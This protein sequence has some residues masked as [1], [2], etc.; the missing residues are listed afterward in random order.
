VVIDVTLQI[1]SLG[2]TAGSSQ[3]VIVITEGGKEVHR[4]PL[5]KVRARDLTTMF[6]LDLAASSG[7]TKLAEARAASRVFLERLDP[8]IDSGLVV[9]DRRIQPPPNRYPAGDPQAIPG[10]R[11]ELIRLT[12][13]AQP[14]GS[15]GYL[16]AS[17]L[18]LDM[19]TKFKG[20]RVV[21]LLTDG[22]NKKSD[23]PAE[24]VIRFANQHRIPVY[25]LGV[26]DPNWSEQVST[27][28]VLD[29]SGSMKEK[30]D[31]ADT[32]SKMDALKD[33]ASRFVDLMK[34]GG[35]AALLP[36]SSRVDDLHDFTPDKGRLKSQIS[37]LREEGGTAFYDAVY[38]GVEAVVA[39]RPEG[40]RHVVALT[41][42]VDEDPGSR[43]SP[44]QV[45]QLAR[46]EGVQLFLLGLGRR[47]D[48]NEEVMSRMAR[49]TG[50]R[51][52]H[53]A[54]QA[55]LFRAFETLSRDIH[56]DGLDE[57]ALRQLAEKTGG[58]YYHVRDV[59]KLELMYNDLVTE[60]K[61]RY[62]VTFPSGN[63]VMDALPS[64][65]DVYVVDAEGKKVS[66]VARADSFRSGLVVAQTNYVVYLV[67]L[68]ILLVLLK[69]PSVLRRMAS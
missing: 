61:E 14:D 28:L 43:H 46:E 53:A 26:G 27:V 63:Q 67:L 39:A 30:A 69:V 57:E 44:D 34:P 55:E 8:K 9:F 37:G 12:E 5:D 54:N 59:R 4:I 3:D 17:H 66:D 29:H 35:K 50:G 52:E 6:A 51:Y 38:T 11:R 41:D 62:T 48:I 21:V 2:N 60:L 68:L 65:I 18:S 16:D 40:K 49:E 24:E 19:L 25:V 20:D 22:I 15:G 45:I 64:D 10:L 58:R 56:R 47:A 1:R 7:K 42:G 36:F 13:Q 33:A 32:R 23:R 31:H